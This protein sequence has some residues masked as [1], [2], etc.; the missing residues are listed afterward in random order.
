MNTLRRLI[1][2]ALLL[3]GSAFSHVCQAKE[4]DAVAMLIGQGFLLSHLSDRRYLGLAYDWGWSKQWHVDH[5]WLLNGYT[6]LAVS[7]WTA[8]IGSRRLN[9]TDVGVTPVF[10]L[11]RTGQE[12]MH[13]YLEGGI[14][15]HLMSRTRLG[16]QVFSTAFQFGEFGGIGLLFGRGLRYDL[17]LRLVHES[18]GDLKTPNDGMDFVL[19]RLALRS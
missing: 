15:A 11:I 7:R 5:T 12:S 6:E 2:A 13:W 17:D 9:L 8:R 1:L 4:P 18:N 14:G 10:R 3:F 16:P 19:L